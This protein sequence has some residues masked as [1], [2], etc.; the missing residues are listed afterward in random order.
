MFLLSWQHPCAV[1][2]GLNGWTSNDEY[3][4]RIDAHD[5]GEFDQ[6]DPARFGEHFAQVVERGFRLKHTDAQEFARELEDALEHW[7]KAFSL[8]CSP[9]FFPLSRLFTNIHTLTRASFPIQMR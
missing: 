3:L 6:L 9:L 8:V 7:K 1:V 4:E 2:S 5:R